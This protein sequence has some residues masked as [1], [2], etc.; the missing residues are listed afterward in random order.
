[1]GRR[2]VAKRKKAPTFQK[3]RHT[4]KMT[5]PASKTRSERQETL[6]IGFRWK[7]RATRPMSSR[8]WIRWEIENARQALARAE[9]TLER[10]TKF[11][12][13]DADA[14]S[15]ALAHTVTAWCR[16]HLGRPAPSD[17]DNYYAFMDNAP[18]AL[19]ESVMKA[20]DAIHRMRWGN[21]ITPSEAATATRA[22]V[23]T[24][25]AATLPVA[26]QTRP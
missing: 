1:M 4:F 12:L 19:S 16:V 5:L 14:L 18:R 11:S 10:K 9:N 7:V 25:L 22:A 13:P 8:D 6:D 15:S 3:G 17:I 21:K 23:D 2:K 24:V 26:N 20:S